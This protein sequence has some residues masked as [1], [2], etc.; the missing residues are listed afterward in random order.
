MHCIVYAKA[1]EF[2]SK[3]K[4][5]CCIF[6]WFSPLIG[7]N[8][9]LISTCHVSNE[10]KQISANIYH[11]LFFSRDYTWRVMMKWIYCL[12]TFFA[13]CISKVYKAVIK[14]KFSIL[15][16]N[17][18][19]EAPKL[20]SYQHIQ[21]SILLYSFQYQILTATC[22]CQV[23]HYQ[24]WLKKKNNTSYFLFCLFALIDALAQLPM[25][26]HSIYLNL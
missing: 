10:R 22:I 24:Q 12:V 15:I 1:S 4:Q 2:V 23:S 6:V 8:I 5:I 20:R 7:L 18:D 21:L 14:I 26:L 16:G 9:H 11:L 13:H 17:K 19:D 3:C 25:N